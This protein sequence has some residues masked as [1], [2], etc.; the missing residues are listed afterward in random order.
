V[1]APPVYAA[2]LALLAAVAAGLVGGFA[3]M[4]R[5]SLAGDAVSHIALPGL[6]LAYLLGLEPALG[7]AAT[8]VLGALVIWRLEGRSGLDT[9][10][11][12]GVVFTA[13]LAL[14]ALLTPNEDLVEALFGA[15]T[16]PTTAEFVGGV[17]LS[18][19][20]LFAVYRYK[21]RFVLALFSPELATSAGLNREHLNLAFLLVFVTTVLLG[22]RF[23]G[24]LLA[25][26]LIIVPAAVARYWTSRFSRFLWV[27]AATSVTSVGVGLAA[28]SLLHR[29]SGPTIVSVAAAIFIGTVLLH[30]K[31]R[32]RR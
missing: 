31:G 29:P 28:A 27:S 15:S 6:G 8:L 21:D 5:M 10:S 13:C 7:A 26:A 4:R 16:L 3:L 11:A 12:V 24:A 19:A 14:G 1:S 32:A 20:V 2:V 25:G 30:P 9:E 22:L 18:A 17:L 23:L